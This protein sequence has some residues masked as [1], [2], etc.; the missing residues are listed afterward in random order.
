[1]NAQTK[2]AFLRGTSIAIIGGGLALLCASLKKRIW[3]RWRS[4]D[5]SQIQLLNKVP[6]MFANGFARRTRVILAIAIAYILSGF[7]FVVGMIIAPYEAAEVFPFWL[8]A[9]FLIIVLIVVTLGFMSW[10]ERRISA[11]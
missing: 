4:I 9:G 5:L 1:M 7:A 2:T 10:R 8:S 6:S 3:N 11:K